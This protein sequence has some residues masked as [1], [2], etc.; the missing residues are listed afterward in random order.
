M[1]IRLKFVRRSDTQFQIHDNVTAHS[2]GL[3]V[4][5]EL[6]E[7]LLFFNFKALCNLA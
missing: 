7:M 4:N 1:T 2:K 6:F 3:N 5:V